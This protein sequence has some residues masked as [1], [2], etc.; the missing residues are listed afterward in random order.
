MRKFEG[1][2]RVAF[3]AKKGAVVLAKGEAGKGYLPDDTGGIMAAIGRELQRDGMEACCQSAGYYAGRD[4]KPVRFASTGDPLRNE[5]RRSAFCP[6]RLLDRSTLRPGPGPGFF[7]P[8][9]CLGAVT[10]YRGGHMDL[11]ISSPP[12]L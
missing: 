2:V 9:I 6:D 10:C 7:L 5:T 8:A 4:G 11:K 1:F 12:L 3:N